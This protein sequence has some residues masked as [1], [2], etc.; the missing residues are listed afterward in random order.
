MK[1]LIRNIMLPV[2]LIALATGCNE[3]DI[4]ELFPSDYQKILYIKDGGDKNVTLYVTGQDVDYSFKVCKGGSDPVQSAAAKIEVMSQEQVDDA[5]SIPYGEKY[6][7]IS[8][9]AFTLTGTELEFTSAD[10][11]K[12]VNVNLKVDRVKELCKNEPDT[13]WLL[14]LKLVSATDS[15]NAD[16]GTYAIIIDHVSEPLVGFKKTGVE[17]FTCDISQPFSVKLPIGLV[18]V[19]N[20]WGLTG[21]VDLDPDFL[22]T[23]NR[24]NGTDYALPDVPYTVSKSFELRSDRQETTVELSIPDFGS[25]TSGSMMIPLR[26]TDVSMFSV[27]P[28]HGRYAALIHLTG[29]KFDRS[30]WSA[31]GCSEQHQE[32]LSWGMESNCQ[33]S[34]VLDG[35]LGTIWHYKYGSKGEGSCA[36]HAGGKHCLMIDMKDKKMLTQIGMCQRAGGEWNILKSVRFWVSDDEAVWKANASDKAGWTA[37]DGVYTFTTALDQ[38]EHIFDIPASEGRYLKIEVVESLK[39]GD[40]GAL[41]EVYCYGK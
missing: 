8:A 14:P 24:D 34:N 11:A 32:Q 40:V 37:V 35:D 30:G 1:Q 19:D 21:T 25:R 3:G 20:R 6:K 27:S 29:H 39:G 13:R 23:Y 31:K 5:Y 12:T 33:A 10:M 9:D 41:A 36:G 7:V 38:H 15:V 26:I 4:Q 17:E 18:D 16:N 28:S 2:A 22:G